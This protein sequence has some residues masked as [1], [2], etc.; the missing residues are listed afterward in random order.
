LPPRLTAD[1]GLD[2]LTHAVEG[3]TSLWHN[4]F[5]DGLCLKAAQL[6]FAFLPRA[7]RDGSDA[8]ARQRMHNAACIAGLGF[9]NSMAA[10]AHGLGH[11]LGA[12]FHLPHGR[13]VG[14]ALPYTIEYCARGEAGS[15]RYTELARFL[16][17]PHASEVEAAAALAAA[18]RAL[19]MQLDQPLTLQACGLTPAD[20]EREMGLLVDNAGND[21]Q[22]VTSTRIP[23]NLEMRRLFEAMYS[24]QPIDF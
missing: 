13:A 4:D 6:V 23:D 10:L 19:A 15:T 24:G 14:L 5:S 1:T 21:T 20:L 7:Y 17:L 8:E 16:D 3:F 18:V 22:T 11:A 2:A 9:G 12:A